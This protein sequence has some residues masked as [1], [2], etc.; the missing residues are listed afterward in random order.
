MF[1]VRW[2]LWP[3]DQVDRGG[4]SVTAFQLQQGPVH[5]LGRRARLGVR[6]RPSRHR[7]LS[8]R[9]SVEGWLSPQK[10]ISGKYGRWRSGSATAA[11]QPIVV[12][13]E[14]RDAGLVDAEQFPVRQR[15]GGIEDRVARG[16]VRPRAHDAPRRLG[17]GFQP[18]PVPASPAQRRP[19]PPGWSSGDHIAVR[20]GGGR[21]RAGARPTRRYR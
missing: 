21:G 13:A 14:H 11:V 3:G 2:Q 17:G 9:T 1:D 12:V 19:S 15:A 10:R 16:R 4:Q 5:L 20:R 7:P 6:T 18:A 8:V